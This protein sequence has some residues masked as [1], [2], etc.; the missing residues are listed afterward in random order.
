M[1][2]TVELRGIRSE[3]FHG[4]VLHSVQFRQVSV[5]STHPGKVR[6]L[7]ARAD[8]ALVNHHLAAPVQEVGGSP[9]EPEALAR[10]GAELVNLRLERE[11]AVN[12]NTKEFNLIYSGTTTPSNWSGGRSQRLGRVLRVSTCDFAKKK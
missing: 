10:L 6:V 4:G 7:K 2:Q 9:E 11:P 1:I 8:E 12:N 3:E 5:G